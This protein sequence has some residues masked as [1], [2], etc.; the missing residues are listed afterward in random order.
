MIDRNSQF[1]AILTNVGAAKLANANAL[2]IPWNL[3]ELGVGDA[4][5]TDPMPSATQTKLINEQRRAPLNQLRVDPVNAAVIIAEQVIPADVGGWWIREIGLYD[6]DGD[7]VAVSNCAPSFKP[8]LDQGSGRTQIVRMNFIVSSVNNIVLKIDPAI[9]LATREYVDLA[10]TEAIN[11]Q[12]FKHSVLVATTA[13]IALTGIQTIDGVLL[14][15]DTRVLV[16]NQAQAKDNGIYLVPSKG[17]WK[18][19]LDADTSIEVTPGLFVHVEK[20]TANAD[21]VWQLVTDAPINLGTTPLDFEM[22]A[23]RTGVVAG[24]YRSLTVDK[25]GRVIA[26]TNPTTLAGAG[27]TDAMPIG[28]GGLMTSAPMVNGAISNLPTT[29][30]IAASEGSTTDIPPG[31]PFAVGLHIKYPGPVGVYALDIVSSVTAEDFR[32]RYTGADGPAPY[33][34]LYHS[35]NFNPDSKV[36]GEN[37]TRVGFKDS[38]PEYPYFWSKSTDAA[39]FLQK[40]LDFT[41]VQQGG[42]V[43]QDNNRVKIGWSSTGLKATVDESDLGLIWCENNFKPSEYIKKGQY[44][45]S[46]SNPTFGS[47]NTGAIGTVPTINTGSLQIS[48]EGNAAASAS[49]CF[50]RSGAYAAYFGLDTDNQFKVGG[51]SMGL[52]SHTL[53]HSGNRPKDTALLEANGWSRNADTGEINQWVEYAIGDTP[54]TTSINVSWKFQFPSQCLNVRPSLKLAANTASALGVSVSAITATGCTVRIEEWAQLVQT[55]LV[56]MVEARGF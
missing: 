3:T 38:N 8:S 40:R 23:G 26:G 11:K 25:L 52:V 20:G 1:M 43:G 16:K 47:G 36:S 9:V 35:G 27:I 42:G 55:G 49:I 51:A 7:L 18:R 17:A 33:H 14:P 48:N 44:V 13:N 4:N 45:P 39:I 54:G 5:G 31:M 2:G 53:W 6:S 10:V 21:S 30:F 46:F 28:A 19:A 41:P 50:H 15:A 32:I 29:Q 22:V 34:T 56:L 37:A 24:T 12:D